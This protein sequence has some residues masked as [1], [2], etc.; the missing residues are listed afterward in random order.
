MDQNDKRYKELYAI[1]QKAVNKFDP[2]DIASIS[3]F[4]YDPEIKDIVTRLMNEENKDIDRK[5]LFQIIK[6]V[7]D[8]WFYEDAENVDRYEAIADAVKILGI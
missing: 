4:E 7:F 6:D 3:P 2:F 8:H 1:V 5:K